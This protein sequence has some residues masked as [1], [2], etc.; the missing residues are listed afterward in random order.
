MN[1]PAN[2]KPGFLRNTLRLELGVIFNWFSPFAGAPRVAASSLLGTVVLLHS[3]PHTAAK[4]AVS[5]SKALDLSILSPDTESGTSNHYTRLHSD[6]ASDVAKRP[7]LAITCGA[8][9]NLPTVAP[10]TASANSTSAVPATLGGSVSNAIA[11]LWTRVSGP[12]EEIAD[13]GTLQ[14]LLVR[15]PPANASSDSGSQFPKTPCLR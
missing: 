1:H 15:F 11:S 8:D 9:P 5:N 14:T 7:K 13:D 2:V 6:E 3:T 4:D 10:G 12:G